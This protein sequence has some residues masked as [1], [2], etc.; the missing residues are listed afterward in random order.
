MHLKLQDIEVLIAFSEHQSVS[1]AADALF[2][3]QPAVTKRIR[4]LEESLGLS[5]IDRSGARPVL[6]ASGEAL[7]AHGRAASAE[8]QR[9]GVE[10]ATLQEFKS[11]YLSIGALPWAAADLVPRAVNALLNVLPQVLVTVTENSIEYLLRD[12]ERGSIDIIVGPLH[13]TEAP[14][15]VIEKPLLNYSLMALCRPTHPFA[16]SETLSLAD[17]KD[18]EWIVPPR[19]LR[20]HSR[21]R[22]AFLEQGIAPPP[23]HIET[24]STPVIRSL[25]LESDR[26]GAVSTAPFA[27]EIALG[28]LCNLDVQLATTTRTVGTMRRASAPLTPAVDTFIARL[29]ALVS[30][31]VSGGTASI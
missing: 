15:W 9:A 18:Q 1:R 19:G 23:F 27:N 12:L 2:L 13:Y 17:L 30:K 25:L 31:S 26:I 22:N 8:L 10:L 7:I 4:R 24:I 11:N 28:L 6:T 29:Q 3:T 16:S 21:W 14:D 20:A 5:L